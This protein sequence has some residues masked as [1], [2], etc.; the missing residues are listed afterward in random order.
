MKSTL[1][2][3]VLISNVSLVRFTQIAKNILQPGLG[4]N[5]SSLKGLL[6]V[7]GQRF[8]NASL[9]LNV[10][11]SLLLVGLISL[12]LLLSQSLGIGV[13]LLHDFFV[14]QRVLFLFV[15]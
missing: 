10:F 8:R 15:V 4:S 6:L 9:G 12:S 5:L 14:F 1:F 11:N 7:L 2:E 3:G 13:Q